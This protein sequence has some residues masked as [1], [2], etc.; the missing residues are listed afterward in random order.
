MYRFSL[1]TV[2]NHRR[3]TEDRLQK[4]FMD[5]KREL[6]RAEEKLRQ[7]E[8]IKAENLSM[9]HNKQQAGASVST[10]VLYDSYI[11]KISMKRHQQRRTIVD[12]KKQLNQKRMALIG[13]MK[14]RKTLDILKEKEWIA[15]KKAE[16]KKDELFLGEI[17]VNRFHRNRPTP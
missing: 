14:N 1:E 13:A 7:L 2:L 12:L 3:H 6:D 11:R 4:A 15:Y 8:G 5:K 16:Q 9:L 10:I 17:A